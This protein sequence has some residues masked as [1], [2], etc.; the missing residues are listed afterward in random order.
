M[1]DD[2][3]CSAMLLWAANLSSA[4][5]LKK[6]DQCACDLIKALVSALL[7]KARRSVLKVKFIRMYHIHMRERIKLNDD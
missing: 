6:C 7:R 1:H 5:Q 2:G 4:K 3:D